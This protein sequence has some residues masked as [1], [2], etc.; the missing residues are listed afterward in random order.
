MDLSVK[1]KGLKEEEE[2][3]CLLTLLHWTFLTGSITEYFCFL[4]RYCGNWSGAKVLIVMAVNDNQLLTYHQILAS[5]EVEVEEYLN[6][7][8]VAVVVVM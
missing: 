6:P 8:L 5:S 7:L 1:I 3:G 4:R 2:E